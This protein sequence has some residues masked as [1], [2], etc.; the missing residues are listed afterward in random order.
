MPT[1]KLPLSGNVA[2]SIWTAFLSPFN[3]Q[4]GLI[5]ISLGKSSAPE[6]EQ[7]VLD[8]V[9]SYGKQLGRVG[10]ALTVLMKH[11][12][13]TEPLTPAEQDALTALRFMLDEIADIKKRHGRKAMCE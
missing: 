12:H 8:E 6:V 11:F 4:I 13:P 10:D 2:Q 1:F 9:G 7:D 5:N 3:N